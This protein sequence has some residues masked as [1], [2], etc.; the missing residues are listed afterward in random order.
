MPRF[1]PPE[2]APLVSLIAPPHYR[3]DPAQG[4]VGPIRASADYPA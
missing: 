3:I 2:P 1:V 4:C